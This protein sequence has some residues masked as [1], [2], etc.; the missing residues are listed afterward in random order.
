MVYITQP[1]MAKIVPHDVRII[2][3]LFTLAITTP[4]LITIYNLYANVR[5]LDAIIQG[6]PNADYYTFEYIPASALVAPSQA[7]QLNHFV[8]LMFGEAA[9]C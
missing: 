1:S 8:A 5:L 2:F 4:L 7:A 9:L 3:V 6:D